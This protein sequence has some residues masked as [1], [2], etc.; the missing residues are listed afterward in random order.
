MYTYTCTHVHVYA[1]AVSFACYGCY[2]F[3]CVC[4]TGE[5]G[6]ERRGG[7]NESV[8]TEVSNVFKG[9]TVSYMYMYIV[10][11]YDCIYTCTCTLYVQPREKN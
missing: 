2:V 11:V 10:H 9:K 8:T 6:A 4:C 7:I 1:L 3:V 5:R